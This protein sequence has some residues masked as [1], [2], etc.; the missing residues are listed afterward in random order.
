MTIKFQT[1]T[2]LICSTFNKNKKA[3]KSFSFKINPWDIKV[4]EV[5]ETLSHC[6]EDLQ[7]SQSELDVIFFMIARLIF[8]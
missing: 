7:R 3:E 6:C 8:V 1:K 4:L 2:V 5:E